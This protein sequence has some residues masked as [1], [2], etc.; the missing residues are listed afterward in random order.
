MCAGTCRTAIA[1]M[2]LGRSVL[3]NDRDAAVVNAGARDALQLM[4]W[5]HDNDCLPALGTDPPFVDKILLGGYYAWEVKNGGKMPP[6]NDVN[7]VAKD[8]TPSGWARNLQTWGS[9]NG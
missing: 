8:S 2:L 3:V 6:S 5:A 1:A 9:Y 7:V 4:A